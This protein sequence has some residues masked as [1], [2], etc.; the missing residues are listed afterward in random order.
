MHGATI[1]IINAIS[2]FAGRSGLS[3]GTWH[4]I[5]RENLNMW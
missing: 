1:K 2:E 3:Y 5:L 4:C